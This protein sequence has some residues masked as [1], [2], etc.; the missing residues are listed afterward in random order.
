MSKH[1]KGP[2]VVRD[3]KREQTVQIDTAD[4]RGTV[5]Q[6]NAITWRPDAKLIAAAPTLLEMLRDLVD[7]LDRDVMQHA[8]PG[9]DCAMCA[10]PN[11]EPA[12]TL[13]A[14][15]ADGAEG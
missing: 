7:R 13:L 15:F 9:F 5:V 6:P 4:G 12:R 14:T 8:C 3:N 1:T 2:W 10:R 11:T